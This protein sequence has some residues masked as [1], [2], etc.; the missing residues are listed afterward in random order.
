MQHS[1]GEMLPT[2]TKNPRF[3]PQLGVEIHF[4]FRNMGNYNN[5]YPNGEQAH[6]KILQRTGIVLGERTSKNRSRCTV[7]I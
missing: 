2:S 7:L 3:C 1:R 5:G 6:S 4:F